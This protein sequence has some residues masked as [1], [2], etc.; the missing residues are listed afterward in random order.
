M[1]G[2]VADEPLQV[3]KKD[4]VRDENRPL[5]IIGHR[6]AVAL[7]NDRQAVEFFRAVEPADIEDSV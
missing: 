1:A 6:L 3:A 7:P 5:V 2:I 4:I